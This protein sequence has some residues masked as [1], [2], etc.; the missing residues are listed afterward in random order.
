MFILDL[1]WCD[2]VVRFDLVWYG[3]IRF[4]LVWL[5]YDMFGLVW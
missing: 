1:N 5:A 4:D 2:W 3:H